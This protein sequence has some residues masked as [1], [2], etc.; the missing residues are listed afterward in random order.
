MLHWFRIVE[1]FALCNLQF[2]IDSQ[3]TISHGEVN[4]KYGSKEFLNSLA[5]TRVTLV[6]FTISENYA[7]ICDFVLMEMLNDVPQFFKVILNTLSNIYFTSS[8]YQM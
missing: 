3:S 8:I 7:S 6:G 4:Q 1:G 5:I 2:T